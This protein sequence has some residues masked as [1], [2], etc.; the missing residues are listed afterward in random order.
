MADEDITQ[1]GGHSGHAFGY[2]WLVVLGGMEY[3]PPLQVDGDP[4]LETVKWKIIS[5]PPSAG[6]FLVP[7]IC[8]QSDNQSKFQ[9]YK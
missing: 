1:D 6:I 3:P 5:V 7:F 4:P 2:R 8:A 9:A